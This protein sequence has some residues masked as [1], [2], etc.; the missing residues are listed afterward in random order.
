MSRLRSY[1]KRQGY[2]IRIAQLK[3][4]EINYPTH[5][6]ELVVVVFALKIWRHYLYATKCQLFTDHKSLKYTFSQQTL[7][8][9]QQR[10]TE[11]IKYYDCEIPYHL[12]K[13]NIVEDVLSRKC[14]LIHHFSDLK[15][16]FKANT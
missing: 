12:D 3:D 13:T 14:M 4:Y 1:G 7:N 16:D 6:L 8:M 9:R 11:L 15:M 5:D 2:H 10:A